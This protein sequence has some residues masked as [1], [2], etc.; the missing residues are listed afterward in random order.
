MTMHPTTYSQALDMARRCAVQLA[1][2]PIGEA[3]EAARRAAEFGCFTDPTAWQAN[4]DKLLIDIKFLE[5]AAQLAALGTKLLD[6]IAADDYILHGPGV[7][8]P[9]GIVPPAV[10]K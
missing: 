10:K 6:Q 4:H 1:T 7:G 3:L 8:R 5:A 2:Q 9:F